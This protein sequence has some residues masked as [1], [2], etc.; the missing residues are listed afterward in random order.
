MIIRII[1]LLKTPWQQTL[2]P[3]DEAIWDIL[4]FLPSQE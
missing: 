4:G 3:A 1:D 2:F